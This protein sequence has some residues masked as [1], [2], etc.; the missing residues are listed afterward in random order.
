MIATRYP[1]LNISIVRE[2][3]NPGLS[4]PLDDSLIQ[5]CRESMEGAGFA[6]ELAKN[7]AST[8][9]AQYFQAGYQAVVFGPGKFTGN[10]HTP[11]E[12]NILDH[13]ENAISFYEK[14]IERVCL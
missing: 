2:R 3:M 12:N 6:P 5:I 11:N 14:I 13:L 8:E 1:N 9:A 4:M 7:S 10:T